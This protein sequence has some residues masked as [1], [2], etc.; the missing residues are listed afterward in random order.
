MRERRPQ[1]APFSHRR[2]G[3]RESRSVTSFTVLWRCLAKLPID[4]PVVEVAR[5]PKAQADAGAVVDVADERDA[6]AHDEV[7]QPAL[8]A[9]TGRF[10]PWLRGSGGRPRKGICTH[11]KSS[12]SLL[13]PHGYPLGSFKNHIITQ[14]ETY[15]TPIGVLIIFL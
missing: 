1:L 9:L 12:A 11:G 8:V 6:R 5:E 4:R 7:L 13:G 10:Q 14:Q 15:R 3:G 2:S